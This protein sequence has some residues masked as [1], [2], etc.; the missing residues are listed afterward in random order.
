MFDVGHIDQA[1]TLV[2]EGLVA[3]PPW[4]QLCMG[5]RWGIPATVDNLLFMHR[6]LPPDA[7]WSVLGVGRH[8]LE[9]TTVAPLMGGHV[10]VGL[11]DNLYYARG[12]LAEVSNA[13]LVPGR[14]A[15]CSCSTWNHDGARSGRDPRPAGPQPAASELTQPDHCQSRPQEEGCCMNLHE[16]QT[17]SL[18]EREGIPV[19]QGAVAMTPDGAR[20]IAIDLGLVV[21]VK[22]QVLTGG[23]GKAGGIRLAGNPDEAEDAAAHILGMDIK[24]LVQRVLVEQASHTGGLYLAA[25]MTGPVSRSW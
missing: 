14:C 19:P 12:V 22:A 7:V 8:Q 4:Y 10:R 24:G 23:R 21:A 3:A 2:R 5:I 25:L 15:F 6:Q 17:K 20:Q 1:R 18:L 13:Q 16:Y 11:E 9:M